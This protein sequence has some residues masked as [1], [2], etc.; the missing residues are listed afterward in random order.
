[1]TYQILIGLTGAATFL[2]GDLGAQES[3]RGGRLVPS[4]SPKPQPRY[5]S[6]PRPAASAP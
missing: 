4:T 5:I 1:M 6:D 2:L 3:R